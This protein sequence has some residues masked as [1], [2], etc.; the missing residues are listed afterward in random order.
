LRGSPTR[1]SHTFA[2]HDIG[3]RLAETDVG[4]TSVGSRSGANV[5]K[6]IRAG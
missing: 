1:A 4:R 2:G 6:K 5:F 3:R